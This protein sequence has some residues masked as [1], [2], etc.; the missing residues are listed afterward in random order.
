MTTKN[1]ARSTAKTAAEAPA[2]EA[3]GV[4][5]PEIR[6]NVTVEGERT[7]YTVT[8][9]GGGDKLEGY[10]VTPAH[11]PKGKFILDKPAKTPDEAIEQFTKMFDKDQVDIEGRGPFY[12]VVQDEKVL[13]VEE[14]RD[15]AVR[16]SGDL[17]EADQMTGTVRPATRAVKEMFDAVGTEGT[18]VN[19]FRGLVSLG[20]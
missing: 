14:G 3:P 6:V 17:G 20:R 8:P 2:V 19:I 13:A 7:E 16:K 4:G 1:T 5:D 9:V 10:N 11:D 12:A 18:R 15:A